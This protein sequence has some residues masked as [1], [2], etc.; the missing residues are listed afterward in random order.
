MLLKTVV[1]GMHSK[2][3][4]LHA[5]QK[6]APGGT[7]KLRGSR[8]M[9]FHDSGVLKGVLFLQRPCQD[10]KFEDNRSS[11]S[12]VLFYTQPRPKQ[13]NENWSEKRAMVS[14]LKSL[15]INEK[16]NHCLLWGA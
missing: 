1:V 6:K 3:L 2:N 8:L 10:S 11:K 14:Y 4:F 7:L 15:N 12:D 13:S 5:R 9:T 16:N